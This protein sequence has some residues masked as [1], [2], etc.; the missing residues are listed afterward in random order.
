M[1]AKPLT[2]KGIV[3][4]ESVPGDGMLHQLR[5]EKQ[6]LEEEILSVR[7]DLDDAR[8]H[9]EKLERSLRALRHQLSPL[10]HALRAVFGEIE[11]AIGEEEFTSASPASSPSSQPPSANDPRWQ[12][13]KNNF[14]GVPAL[15]IDA[16]LSHP[17]LSTPQLA[18]IIKRAY[19]TTKDAIAKLIKAGAV[20]REGGRIRLNR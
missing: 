5:R 4:A 12:S 18:T 3:E 15:I 6:R 17:D 10:H 20:V 9:N 19:G 13:Y 7:R 2:L 14:P 1:S 11:L 8:T 16:L